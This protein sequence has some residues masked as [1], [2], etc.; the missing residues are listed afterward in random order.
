MP[1]MWRAIYPRE[2]GRKN[3]GTDAK[4]RNVSSPGDYFS[5]C[6]CP[7]LIKELPLDCGQNL[8]R[9]DI[10]V[11]AGNRLMAFDMSEEI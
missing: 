2:M 5:A 7:G 8:G 1:S 3:R 4:G 11:D 9:Q 6:N 10:V